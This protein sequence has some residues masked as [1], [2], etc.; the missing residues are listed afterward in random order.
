M[1]KRLLGNSESGKFFIYVSENKEGLVTN[2]SPKIYGLQ[3]SQIRQVI[4]FLRAIIEGLEE[5][6]KI[7]KP[8]NGDRKKTG[9]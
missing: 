8:K 2:V 7:E 9:I 4:S 1:F 3:P 5:F 6:I